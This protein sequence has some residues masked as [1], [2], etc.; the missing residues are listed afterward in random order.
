MWK[1][2]DLVLFTTDLMSGIID[3][4][5]MEPEE[6]KHGVCLTKIHYLFSPE[7]YGFASV[8]CLYSIKQ[9]TDC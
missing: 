5:A 8:K 1:Y 4:R 9:Y 6:L 2:L 7:L 3:F